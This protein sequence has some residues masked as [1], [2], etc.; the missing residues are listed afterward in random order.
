MPLLDIFSALLIGI[1]T[2]IVL[3]RGRVC[4]NSAFRNILLARNLELMIVITLAVTIELVG[5]QFLAIFPFPGLSFESNPISFSTLLLP[6][7]GFLFGLGTVFAGGC[8]GGICYRIGEGSAKSLTA[9]LGFATGIGILSIEPLSKLILDLRISTTWLINS[10]VPSLEQIF[11]RW[12]WTLI[13]LIVIFPIIYYYKIQTKRLTHLLPRWTPV[14]S[15]GLLGF[16]G[17]ISR[18]FSTLSGRSFGFSTTD[19]IGEIFQVIAGFFGFYPSLQ[20]SWAG[21]FIIGLILG[22]AV[23]SLQNHEFKLK[24]PN[25]TDVVR[26]FGGGFLMGS[27]AMLAL[28]CNFGHILGGIP[29]LG[30]SSLIALIFMITGNWFGS[31]FVYRVME[32]ELPISTPIYLSIK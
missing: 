12:F 18:F 5:Y 7:G 10:Q 27:G 26:F 6:V 16:L 22:A 24:I 13:A 4:T 30:L 29:E 11:P 28:G 32:Q 8:A 17:V 1:C 3:Q 15:G 19:G 2:G 23:S 31:Y 20:L 25:K 21:L 9:F 14:V